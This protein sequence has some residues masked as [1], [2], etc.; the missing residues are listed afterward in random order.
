MRQHKQIW[1]QLRQTVAFQASSE[2][3]KHHTLLWAFYFGFYH[4]ECMNELIAEIYVF[5]CISPL[6]FLVKK[7]KEK[8]AF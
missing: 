7:S 5:G 1:D 6:I 4:L 3:C 8:Y 2:D